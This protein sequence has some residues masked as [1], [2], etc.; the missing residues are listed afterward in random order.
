M[1][2]LIKPLFLAALLSVSGAGISAQETENTAASD[3]SLGVP[4]D[5]ELQPGQPYVREEHQSQNE[6]NYNKLNLSVN[7]KETNNIL[8]RKIPEIWNNSS[9]NIRSIK[10]KNSFKKHIKPIYI[11]IQM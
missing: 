8:T 3:L 11:D 4:V 2:S 6:R 9:I 10:N 7:R 5:G 1:P